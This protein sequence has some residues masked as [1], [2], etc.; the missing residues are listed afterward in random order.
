M[1]KTP[2]LYGTKTAAEHLGVSVRTITRVS[3]DLG[4]SVHRIGG[5]G[6]IIYTEAQLEAIRRNL[7]RAA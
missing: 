7:K 1:K 2:R 3:E 4:L 6:K 5:H